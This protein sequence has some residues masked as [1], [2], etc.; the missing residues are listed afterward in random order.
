MSNASLI[1]KL[2]Q[3]YLQA[4]TSHCLPDPL[5]GRTGPRPGMHAASSNALTSSGFMRT[6][7]VSLILYGSLAPTPPLPPGQRESIVYT[8]TPT[9]DSMWTLSSDSNFPSSTM[10]GGLVPYA[11]DPSADDQD[12]ADEV[13]SLHALESADKPVSLLKSRSV[14]NIGVLSSLAA[15]S[16]SSLHYPL[17][18]T[19]RTRRTPSSPTSPVPTPSIHLRVLSMSVHLSILILP[20]QPR[21][22]CAKA[23][24]MDYRR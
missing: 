14:S 13:D 3:C 15:S 24:R 18:L 7:I 16:G 11:W 1:S 17:S 5:L 6:S 20:T 12:N 19:Y 4:L 22:A 23:S 8:S 2:Y 9:R 21:L 10:R